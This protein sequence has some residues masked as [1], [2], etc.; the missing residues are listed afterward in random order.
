METQRK[1]SGLTL[2]EFTFQLHLRPVEKLA[3]QNH[4]EV[5]Q[6]VLFTRRQRQYSHKEHHDQSLHQRIPL[7]RDKPFPHEPAHL[8]E[9][10][11][12]KERQEQLWVTSTMNVL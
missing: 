1:H 11:H 2:P 6:M 8:L 12:L 7:G 9:V 10:Q 4:A 5:T 3:T